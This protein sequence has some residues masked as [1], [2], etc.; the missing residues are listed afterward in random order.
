MDA[1]L[2]SRVRGLRTASALGM[3]GVPLLI[4]SL[5]LPIYCGRPRDSL[6]LSR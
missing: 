2:P 6:P 5:P 4:F 3:L 1:R